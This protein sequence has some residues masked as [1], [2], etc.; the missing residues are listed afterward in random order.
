MTIELL[1]NIEGLSGISDSGR[2]TFEISDSQLSYLKELDVTS[3]N[4]ENM[5]DSQKGMVISKI[6]DRFEEMNI[7]DK[8][9]I[10]DAVNASFSPEIANDFMSKFENTL[11]GQVEQ[12]ESIGLSDIEKRKLHEET[13]WSDQIIDVIKTPAEAEV[14]KQ[15]GLKEMNGNLER[16]DIDWNAKIPQD[17][18]DR[19]RSLYGDEVAD[20]WSGK[21]NM[22]LIKEGKAPYGPDGEWINLH[23]IGQKPDSPLAELTNTEQKTYDSILHD[24]TKSSEIERPVFRTEKQAYWMNRYA[25]L[26]NIK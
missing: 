1:S 12:T 23:H 15:A 20:R 4:W 10:N 26:N 8:N 13:G 11:S 9:V 6:N 17:K 14:Y 24:K 19:M 25:E 3:E 16:L 7:S 22:D 5:S 21:T 18:I 2:T